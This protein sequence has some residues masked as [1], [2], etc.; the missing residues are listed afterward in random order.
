MIDAIKECLL[1]I[2][3]AVECRSGQNARI[4]EKT[5]EH[6]CAFGP[7]PVIDAQ[8]TYGD[9]QS[10]FDPIGRRKYLNA[11]ERQR[12]L[13]AASN[14][15]PQI[16][17]L[18]MVLHF[19]GCRI[20]EAL[21]LQPTHL[22]PSEGLII[23]T[24]LKQRRRG[25]FRTV[26]VPSELMIKLRTCSVKDGEPLFPWHRSTAWE[27]ISAVFARAGITG[28]Q[29]TPR[30]ARHGFGVAGVSAGVPI[31]LVQRWLGHSRLETTSIYLAI[32][33]PEERRYA[34]RLWRHSNPSFSKEEEFS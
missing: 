2:T 16:E 21:A 17:A 8:A 9:P 13:V 30:G 3:N 28:P 22:D 11:D 18:C 5:T 25:V 23:L 20:S 12:F 14:F 24:T 26:P 7:M 34:Q 19:T 29:A 1:K 31:T 15:C 32:T 6:S 33:G 27:K 10:L 4:L